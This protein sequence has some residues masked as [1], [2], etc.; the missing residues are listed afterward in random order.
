MTRQFKQFILTLLL[1]LSFV[2]YTAQFYNGSY[3]EFGKNRVQ[4]KE[5]L[6]KYYQFQKFDVY[7]Y[8][9]GQGL[10]EHIASI[11]EEEIKQ[12]ENRLD[13]VLQDKIEFIIY[14]SH[15]DFKQSNVG[16]DQSQTDNIGGATQIVGS[17]VFFYYEGE[18]NLLLSNL[19]KGIAQVLINQMMYGGNWRD[20]FKNSTLLNLPDWYM[21]G[22]ISWAADP[23]NPEVINFVKDGAEMGKFKQ[24]NWLR[25][26]EAIYA[27]HG[28]WNY[29]EEVYGNSVIPN[30]LYMSRISRNVESGFLFVLG[31]SLSTLQSEFENYYI[32]KY[33]KRDIGK[34][35][36]T[37]ENIEYKS[38]K[39]HVYS[40]IKL[41]P[42]EEKVAFVSNI[43]G[44]YR[45][46]ILD[47]ETGKQRKIAKGD[48]KLERAVD[49]SWPVVS[50]SPTGDELAYIIE[51]R[52][53]L[54][55]HIYN[56][57]ENK[58]YKRELF[59][60]D[61]VLDMSYSHDGRQ[62]VFSAVKNG[63]TDLYLYYLIGNRQEKLTNDFFEEVNP[64]FVRKS[65]KIIFASNRTNDTL[66]IKSLEKIGPNRDIF[67]LNLGSRKKLERITNTP[68][69][70]EI[71]PAQ[72]DS[73]RYTFLGK[74]DEFYSQ[75]L[76]TYDSAISRIDTT[77]HYRYFTHT[78]KLK[79][80]KKNIVEHDINSRKREYTM[81]VYNQGE[82]QFY[83]GNLSENKI[84]NSLEEEQG[85]ID[86]GREENT[87]NLIDTQVIVVPDEENEGIDIS[88]YNFGN[89]EE[90]TYEQNT[91]SIGAPKE[92]E[93]EAIQLGDENNFEKISLPG[94]RNY[95]VN[96]T[97]EQATTQI[98][99]SFS[100]EYY[101]TLFS[102][103]TP[104]RNVFPGGGLLLK[105]SMVDLFEDYRV[106]AGFRYSIDFRSNEQMIEF[107]NLKKRM[108]KFL[109]FERMVSE[110][111]VPG[112]FDGSLS[113]K[114][115]INVL[116]F[117]LKY[118]INEVLRLE[119]VLQARH[120]RI[121]FLAQDD[122][123]LFIPNFY[124][125]QSGLKLLTVFDNTLSLGLN[126][127]EGSRFKIW[128]EYYQQF[129]ESDAD[130]FVVGADFRNYI[131]IHRNLIF[132]S[133]LAGSTSFGSERLLYILGGVDQWFVPR[134]AE[135]APRINPDQNFQYQTLA[136]PVRGFLYNA[137]NGNSFAVANAELRLP[138]FRYFWNRPMKSDFLDSFQIIGFGDVGTAWTG[139][140]PY[141]DENSFNTE[142]INNGPLTVTLK[143]RNEP[144]VG[145][146]G[147]GLRSRLF[148]Y[149]IRADW[150]WGIEDGNA[151][152][153]VFYLSTSLDF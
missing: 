12:I 128:G 134:F 114:V 88:D 2:G 98:N 57:E 8:E 124:R 19:R 61:K 51:K 53:E 6:W 25:G 72:Y 120:D 66:S 145:G 52:G 70:D 150:A 105:W 146:V 36:F 54:Y 110:F 30:I 22:L 7:F 23:K 45:I 138:F 84:S 58:T 18:Y 73:I 28:I 38:K 86:D 104:G 71:Q 100:N 141:S 151:S 63:Q 85:R 92:K 17:K 136:S 14:N 107:Q 101:Q 99:N 140:D 133:R 56:L 48:H 122:F 106:F 11:A 118:P 69:I 97:A 32:E 68:L 113:Y 3:Q 89:T 75:Y 153:R 42:L 80:Y 79:E 142:V 37:Q 126:L 27:G 112:F 20:V 67:V 78:Q 47:L 132:A 139:S 41:N 87:E 74:E 127:R 13:Y 44:Q 15:T 10:S 149:F 147:F 16:L 43:L 21:S 144:I 94:A 9:G 129:Q 83:R 82:Y 109:R 95:F 60:L 1:G 148:G 111:G 91:I 40:Q 135:N 29:I 119:G 96:F 39:K 26:D 116:N 125:Y 24:F 131:R 121:A 5:F 103:N 130:F 33:K 108:D 34:S 50:W 81:L 90:N 59:N 49:R 77:I 65:S 115:N 152:E 93:N 46:Y 64:K 123:S 76:A 55:L 62:M 143:G 102:S 4:H 117:G 35:E 137:R 31:M